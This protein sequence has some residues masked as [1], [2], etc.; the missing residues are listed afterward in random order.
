MGH[1]LPIGFPTLIDTEHG[2]RRETRDAR[3]R[4]RRKRIYLS[5]DN[6][7]A[8]IQRD[9]PGLISRKTEPAIQVSLP[10]RS[11]DEH[12]VV[13]EPRQTLR[14]ICLRYFGRFSLR[15]VQQIQAQS[16][17]RSEQHRD[18]TTDSI[19]SAS[20]PAELNPPVAGRTRR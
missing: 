9:C 20:G 17:T 13:V 11:S 7:D 12:V 16:W 14:Q 15:T 8:K 3:S 10:N 18:R 6:P 2:H 19:A 4:V 5:C 1:S